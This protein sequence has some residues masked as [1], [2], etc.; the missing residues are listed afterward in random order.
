MSGMNEKSGGKRKNDKKNRKKSWSGFSLKDPS[1]QFPADRLE[2]LFLCTPLIPPFRTFFSP[3]LCVCLLVVL[4]S[5]F[6]PS[7]HHQI[8]HNDRVHRVLAQGR[9]ACM[10]PLLNFFLL[11]STSS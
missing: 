9:R 10:Y 5:L 8:Q 2:H 6:L 7:P 3:F 1:K 11:S 4:I